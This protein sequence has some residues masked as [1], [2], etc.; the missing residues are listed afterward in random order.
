MKSVMHVEVGIMVFIKPISFFS[1]DT[2]YSMGTPLSIMRI[3]L[4]NHM[5]FLHHV[6][7]LEVSF[8]KIGACEVAL[9]YT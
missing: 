7:P 5:Q 4:K 2:R 8:T 3:F 6:K 1:H 9:P